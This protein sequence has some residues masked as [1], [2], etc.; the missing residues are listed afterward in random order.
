MSTEYC[1][2]FD[3]RYNEDGD[4]MGPKC[5]TVDCDFCSNRPAK[6]ID[7]CKT[8][9]HSLIDGTICKGLK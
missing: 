9:T 3:V 6:L 1:D 2:R 5:G 7:A 4:Y 8:C